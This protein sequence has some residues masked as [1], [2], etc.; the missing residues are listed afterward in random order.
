MTTPSEDRL[1]AELGVYGIWLLSHG[2]QL[3]KGVNAAGEVQQPEG[4][5]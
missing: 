5:R 1:I 3:P 4:V 2:K